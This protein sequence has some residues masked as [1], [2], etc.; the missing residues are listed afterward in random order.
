MKDFIVGLL[1]DSR[2]QNGWHKRYLFWVYLLSTFAA[3][4]CVTQGS[5][6]SLITLYPTDDV[7]IQSFG[8]G[9]GY[10]A[11]LK[12]DISSIPKNAIIDSCFLQVY[13]H[14]KD[15]IENPW[16]GDVKFWN[17]NSQTWSEADSAHHIWAIPTSDT[18]IQTANFGTVENTWTRSV[19]LKDIL[20]PN[21]NAGDDYCSFKIKDVDDSTF[22]VPPSLPVNSP[23][24]IRVGN[25]LDAYI[26]FRPH[27]NPRQPKLLVYYTL[28]DVGTRSIVLPRGILDS[29]I[30][31]IPTAWIK[32][33][34]T[35]TASFPAV[36]NIRKMNYS[37]TQYISLLPPGDSIRQEFTPCTLSLRGW[38]RAMCSTRYDLDSNPLNDKKGVRFGVYRRYR[39]DFNISWSTNNPPPGWQ[40]KW[41]GD[42]SS[43]DWHRRDSLSSPWSANRTP[44]AAIVYLASDD[45]P[46]SLISWTLDLSEMNNV[47]LRCSTYFRSYDTSRFKA[48]ILGIRGSD[49]FLIREYKESFGPDVETFRLDWA[50]YE[51]EIKIAWVLEGAVSGIYWW[52]LDNVMIYGEEV[53]HNDCGIA[54]IISPKP[55]ELPDSIIPIALVKNF[56]LD[57]QQVKVYCL[58]TSND[59]LGSQVYLESL[60]TIPPLPPLETLTVAFPTFHSSGGDY[61]IRFWTELVDTTDE[62][63]TN[64]EK[65]QNWTISYLYTYL[66]DDSSAITDT[67]FYFMNEGIGVRFLPTHYPYK[68][69]SAHFYFR[70]SDTLANRYK[71]R[72]LADDG[73]DGSPGTLLWESEG[74]GVLPGWNTIDLRSRDLIIKEGGFYL[75]YLSALPYPSGPYL[76][77][78]RARNPIA[79]DYYYFLSAD[80]IY[81]KDST[82]GD[83]MIRVT[84]DFRSPV[85]GDTDARVV[86]VFKPRGELALRPLGKEFPILARVE[87]HGVTTIYHPQPTV[88]CTVYDEVGNILFW[89][90]KVPASESLLSLT[91]E[92]IQFSPFVPPFPGRYF[93]RVR[94]ILSGDTIPTNDTLTKEIR[95]DRAYFTG[96]PDHGIYRN[97]WIDSDT[98]GGPL[99]QWID[100]SNMFTLLT[101]GDGA[102]VEIPGGIPFPF[103]FYD[104]AYTYLRVSCD[105]WLSFLGQAVLAP[106]N[107][108]IP[109]ASP[110]NGCLYPIGTI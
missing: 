69:S 8:V 14:R 70:V 59:T 86:T 98:I 45:T 16:D 40:I 60:V 74:L 48:K 93:I 47:F 53:F 58:I 33:F 17:V 42:T 100:T 80:S 61:G 26:R 19:D 31:V 72:L 37:D 63:P 68:V 2:Q 11:F 32:N 39:E 83:W 57:T 92:W 46:D 66:Y 97:Y 85:L 36:F 34:G 15:S 56:G 38:F 22:V 28:Y 78:D 55:H 107:R 88:V 67:F 18:I 9:V 49:T 23:N 3:I 94:T 90:T 35:D 21:Y 84:V 79:G 7:Y 81:R 82:P 6:S 24:E 10:N 29:G 99:F 108:T 77:R 105:G 54:E 95:I 4:I 27:E 109:N 25:L 106:E 64:D 52:C 76:A 110:P 87:N 65:A 43:S 44:Y 50:D 5:A 102:S 71:I 96:G 13:V 75:F 101:E 73:I 12:F 104:T 51:R 1:R 20:L 89:D 103:P 91:G 62:N 41:T 30:V